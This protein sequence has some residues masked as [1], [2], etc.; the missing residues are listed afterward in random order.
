M[1]L[2]GRVLS[3]I[4]LCP[5]VDAQVSGC[6]RLLTW[7]QSEVFPLLLSLP[8]PEP[9]LCVKLAPGENLLTFIS[10]PLLRGNRCII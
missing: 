1:H 9:G 4:L 3:W 10:V 7:G 6:L 2:P 8:D 5:F